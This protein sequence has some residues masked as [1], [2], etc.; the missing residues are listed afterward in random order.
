[1]ECIFFSYCPL[2]YSS[3]FVFAF[4][5][6][7]LGIFTWNISEKVLN[8]IVLTLWSDLSTVSSV[9]GECNVGTKE[10]GNTVLW[11]R[12]GGGKCIKHFDPETRKI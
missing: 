9:I 4:Y 10:I 3:C 5:F 6:T 2:Y 7:L 1:M 11:T 8:A 12:K